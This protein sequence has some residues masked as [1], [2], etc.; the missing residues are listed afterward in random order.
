MPCVKT[1]Q[2]YS[3]CIF[4]GSINMIVGGW[5]F[6]GEFDLNIRYSDAQIVNLTNE[7]TKYNNIP[8]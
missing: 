4:S 1:N 2:N 8:D 6:V 7:T 5:G 3:Q